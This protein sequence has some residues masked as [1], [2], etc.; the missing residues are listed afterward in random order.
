ML[1]RNTVIPQRLKRSF[2]ISE[3]AATSVTGYVHR[4]GIIGRTRGAGETIL[5]LLH[6]GRTNQKVESMGSAANV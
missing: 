3:Y 1:L 2:H 6:E 5:V 4:S